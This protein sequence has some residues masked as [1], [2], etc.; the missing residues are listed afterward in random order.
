MWESG[1]GQYIPCF[2]IE[3]RIFTLMIH[4]LPILR[5][6]PASAGTVIQQMRIYVPRCYES[7]SSNINFL[8]TAHL[9][10]MLTPCLT[11]Y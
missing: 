3:S 7:S 1:S 4:I 10:Y 9:V 6:E 11:N 5:V 2:P 8:R